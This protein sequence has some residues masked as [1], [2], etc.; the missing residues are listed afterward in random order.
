MLQKRR[1]GQLHV[2]EQQLSDLR[3][4][5]VPPFCIVI[6]LGVLIVSGMGVFKE[7]G[8]FYRGAARSYMPPKFP[9]LLPTCMGGAEKAYS[10]EY[11]P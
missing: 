7:L 8:M 4:R 9:T 1:W 10:P 6:L 2:H 3:F 5:Q 11:D